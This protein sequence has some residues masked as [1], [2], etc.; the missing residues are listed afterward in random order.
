MGKR[1]VT[2]TLWGFAGYLVGAIGGGW[3]VSLLSSNVHDRSVEAAMTGIFVVGPLVAAVM[4][5]IGFVRSRP[6]G[7]VPPPGPGVDGR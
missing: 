7:P 2:A 4:F 5:A 6:A 1:L 3:L